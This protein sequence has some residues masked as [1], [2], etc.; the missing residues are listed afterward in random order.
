MNLQ[1]PY[2][3]NEE[4]QVKAGRNQS[5][6]QRYLC[7]VCQ[8]VYTPK[9]RPMGYPS[10]LRRQAR[11]MHADGLSFRAI[12]RHLGVGTQSVINWIRLD[13]PANAVNGRSHQEPDHVV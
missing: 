2:C 9:P 6:S 4:D 8:R 11:S 7:K 10:T 1:C 3:E 5:G 13:A 12:A